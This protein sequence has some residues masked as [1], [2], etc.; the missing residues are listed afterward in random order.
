MS[1][2]GE[3]V[4]IIGQGVESPHCQKRKKK[5]W[6]GSFVGLIEEVLIIEIDDFPQQ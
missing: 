1:G 3:R 2:K 4:V 5:Y 6:E